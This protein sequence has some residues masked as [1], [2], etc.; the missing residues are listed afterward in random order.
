MRTA[1]P[2]LNPTHMP[3]RNGATVV[4]CHGEEAE[5]LDGKQVNWKVYAADADYSNIRPVNIPRGRIFCSPVLQ[6]VGEGVSLTFIAD[7]GGSGMPGWS[8]RLWECVGADLDHLSEPVALSPFP[9]FCGCKWDGKIVFSDADNV[10][11]VDGEKF[12][13]DGV[14]QI[15]RAVPTGSSLLVTVALTVSTFCTVLWNGTSLL[16]IKAQD[17]LDIYK[18][19]LIDNELCLHAVRGTNGFEDR[20]VVEEGY[21]TTPEE[22]ITVTKLP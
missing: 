16:R 3:F 22:T 7:V 10:L 19:C 15:M 1:F 11:S 13:F 5:I 21:S 8:P 20:T 2:A 12:Q 4:F 9:V 14:H 18:S 17:G 6:T